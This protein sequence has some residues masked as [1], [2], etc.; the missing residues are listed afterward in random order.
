MTDGKSEGSFDA[1]KRELD[2]QGL[3]GVP[4][5]SISFGNVDKTQLEN[6]GSHTSGRLFDGNKDL[7]DAFR[8]A[9][10]YN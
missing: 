7:V 9:K 5:Y 2:R 8:K 4:V 6:L 10:G 1:F 3:R